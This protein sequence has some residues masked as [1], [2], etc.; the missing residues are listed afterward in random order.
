MN[1]LWEK[2]FRSGE[3]YVGGFDEEDVEDRA[4]SAWYNYD[5]DM[6]TYD[7]GDTDHEE[8]EIRDP[9]ISS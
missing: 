6:E 7:Y 4:D 5:V 3:A 2:I 8:L 9:R 1:L